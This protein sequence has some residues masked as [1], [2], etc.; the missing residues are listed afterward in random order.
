MGNLLDMGNILTPEEAN[1]IFSEGPETVEEQSVDVRDISIQ[2][3]EEIILESKESEK[4]IKTQFPEKGDNEVNKETT[5]IIPEDIFG[6]SESVGRDLDGQEMEDTEGSKSQGS[7]PTDTNFYSSIA[8][9]LKEEGVLQD[10]TSEDIEKIKDNVSFKKTKKKQISAGMNEQ[11]RRIKEALDSGVQTNVIQNY[12]NTIGFL[13]S[14]DKASIEDESQKGQ[15]LRKQLIFQDYLN[16]GYSEEKA[17]RELSK[18]LNAGTDIQDALDAL[19]GNKQHFNNQYQEL[20]RE[21]KQKEIDYKETIQKQADELKK[22][23]MEDREIF[24][25]VEIEKDMR[26]KIYDSISKPVYKTDDGQYFNNIQKYERENKQDFMKKIGFLFAYTDGF[27][28]LDKIIKPKVNKKVN[29]ALKDLENKINNTRRTSDGSLNLVT[30]V[31]EDPDSLISS[32]W[33]LDV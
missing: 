16:R 30:S 5:E 33:T 21:N 24:E 28:N 8:E 19:Q 23:I 1:N 2:G 20:I 3:N 11:E 17:K 32:G 10:L 26:Q 18:S 4:E 27:K 31:K 7:S 13:N 29:S 9:A 25:G 14:V 6:E 22:S 15:V 12:E